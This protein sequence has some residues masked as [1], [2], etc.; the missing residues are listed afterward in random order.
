MGQDKARRSGIS[1]VHAQEESQ[2]FRY[3]R[4]Y[5]YTERTLSGSKE[6]QVNIESFTFS[7]GLIALLD[8]LANLTVN[9]AETD[10]GTK[11]GDA[12]TDEPA[13]WRPKVTLRRY[14]RKSL[15]ITFDASLI[16]VLYVILT[17]FQLLIST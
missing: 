4:G 11:T 9:E 16:Y 7:F 3:T 14:S 6:W 10:M 5:I 15:N 17:L 1:K 13:R 12:A 2:G 8:E